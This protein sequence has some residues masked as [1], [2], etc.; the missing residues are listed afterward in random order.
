MTATFAYSLFPE[1]NTL[2]YFAAYVTLIDMQYSP[3][4]KKVYLLVRAADTAA[5]EERVYNEV[6]TNYVL[7][8]LKGMHI[9]YW[10]YIKHVLVLL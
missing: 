5:A 7:F 3:D 10:P 4:V 2:N 6:Q 9:Y 1:V 8:F